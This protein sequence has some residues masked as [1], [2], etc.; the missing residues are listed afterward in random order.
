MAV[1]DGYCLTVTVRPERCQVMV[2]MEEDLCHDTL[3]GIIEKGLAAEWRDMNSV[4]EWCFHWGNQRVFPGDFKVCTSPSLEAWIQK[5]AAEA[6]G[7]EI[8]TI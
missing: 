1:N 3:I 6:F 4:A 7:W 5:R 8:P 2:F